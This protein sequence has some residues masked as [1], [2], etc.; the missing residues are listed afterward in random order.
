MIA[1]RE[2]G[3]PRHVGPIAKVV[4]EHD[5]DVA[6]RGKVPRG[7]RSFHEGHKAGVRQVLQTHRLAEVT[8]TEV[9][10]PRQK[11]DFAVGIFEIDFFAGAFGNAAEGT[12]IAGQGLLYL[13]GDTFSD[14]GNNLVDVPPLQ[15]RHLSH[16]RR[17]RSPTGTLEWLHN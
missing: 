11:L 1:T 4:V 6:I 13:G 15:Y 14:S 12:D 5:A 2:A 10:E 16:A 8:D 9:A 3:V 7:R 17:S